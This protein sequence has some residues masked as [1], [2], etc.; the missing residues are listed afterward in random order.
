MDTYIHKKVKQAWVEGFGEGVP[1]EGG[2]LCVQGDSDALRLASPLAVHDPAGQ[3][4]FQTLLGDSQQ[5]GRERQ[6]CRNMEEG[7]WYRTA[8]EITST[9]R[10]Q[11]RGW[12]GMVCVCVCNS[13]SSLSTTA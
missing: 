13:Q 5:V 10:A 12:F 2:L 4:V 11:D 6:D 3:L 1:C 7:K 9:K 8:R